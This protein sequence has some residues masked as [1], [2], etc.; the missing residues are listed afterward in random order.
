MRSVLFVLAVFLFLASVNSQAQPASDGSVDTLIKS[1]NGS[2]AVCKLKAMREQIEAD[3]EKTNA[4]FR[5]QPVPMDGP[6]FKETEK[7]IGQ[8]KE[9]LASIYKAFTAQYEKKPQALQSGRQ[10]FAA[11]LT[12]L[13]TVAPKPGERSRQYEA[14]QDANEQRMAELANLLKID[15]L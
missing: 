7:C 14:R 11:A 6:S 4:R 15:A 8:E 3:S 5:N 2:I 9:K 13:E 1:A 12:S 10:Y